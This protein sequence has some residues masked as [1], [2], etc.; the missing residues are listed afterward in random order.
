MNTTL[1]ME[2][3]NQSHQFGDFDSFSSPPPPAPPLPELPELPEL[4]DALEL[5]PQA[6]YPTREALLKAIQLW[7]KT[8]GYA[9]TVGKS[10]KLPSGRQEVCYACDRCAPHR[11]K[12]DEADRAYEI[13]VVLGKLLSQRFGA[14]AEVGRKEEAPEIWG[15]Q[16]SVAMAAVGPS[17]YQSVG[18]DSARTDRQQN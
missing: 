12:R 10:K 17:H 3:L 8:Q 6:I 11:E 16:S 1:E 15:R 14:A 7:A 5:P 2:Q 13:R 18:F 4:P 9:F